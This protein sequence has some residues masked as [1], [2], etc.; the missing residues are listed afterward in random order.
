[1]SGSQ[2]TRPKQADNRRITLEAA[3]MTT[4]PD[5]DFQIGKHVRLRAW[6]LKGLAAL[7][8]LLVIVIFAGW[9]SGSRLEAGFQ[10]VVMHLIS[11][12]EKA[13]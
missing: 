7:G 9:N 1:L 4:N 13:R 11:A 3:S 5:F 8:L 12:A 6:N 2:L 10:S